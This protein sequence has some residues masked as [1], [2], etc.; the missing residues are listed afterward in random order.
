MHWDDET[1]V[2]SD[3]CNA[4]GFA[5]KGK[6]PIVRL[7]AKKSRINMVSA[8]TNQDKVGFMLYQEPMTSQIFIKFLS[9]QGKDAKRKDFLIL[10][11]HRVH[12]SKIV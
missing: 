2:Q 5:S 8:I 6:T 11:N 7:N 9:R 4:K 10:G 1:G 12:H 3:A